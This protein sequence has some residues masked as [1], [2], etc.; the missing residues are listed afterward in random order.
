MIMTSSSLPSVIIPI[1]SLTQ[2]AISHLVNDLNLLKEVIQHLT[3]EYAEAF[4]TFMYHCNAYSG[5]NM[6]N[7]QTETF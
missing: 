5:Y 2:Y 6:F 7:H 1:T 4:H 3:P